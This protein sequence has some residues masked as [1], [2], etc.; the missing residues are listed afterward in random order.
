MIELL[1]EA[2]ENDPALCPNGCG[3]SYKENIIIKLL[4]VAIRSDPAYCPNGCGR[5]YKGLY[6]KQNLKHHL[7]YGCGVDPQFK[8]TICQKRL[9][10]KSF[11]VSNG[12][13]LLTGIHSI[14]VCILPSQLYIYNSGCIH[15]QNIKLYKLLS[16]A[17]ENDPAYCPNGC[18]RSYKGLY[19]KQNLKHHLIYGCGV[20]PQ[21]KC[22]NMNKLINEASKYD[23]AFCPNGCGRSY[24][25]VRRKGNLK[26]HLIYSCGVDPQFKCP[27]CKKLLTQK[28]SLNYHLATVHKQFLTRQN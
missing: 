8:C 13:L 2:I 21:F 14:F 6:R 5:S 11:F 16:V 7:I 17:I 22:R 20:D 28:Q 24:R 12:L 9:R 19:R 15:V 23:P 10:K 25:G 27:L 26:H 18:G 4:N 3:R 1:N